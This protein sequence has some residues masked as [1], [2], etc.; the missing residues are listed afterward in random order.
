MFYRV[1]P[2]DARSIGAAVAIL[3]ATALLAGFLPAQ[4]ASHVDPM[5]ALRHE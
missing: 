2:T 3:A 5:I 1:T 4:R